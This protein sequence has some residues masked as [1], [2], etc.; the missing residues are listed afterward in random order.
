MEAPAAFPDALN[1]AVDIDDY[2]LIAGSEGEYGREA[3]RRI[4]A[5]D[6]LIDTID[7]YT[8]FD[9]LGRDKMEEDGVR[10]TGFGLLRRLSKPF[11]SEQEI[12]QTMV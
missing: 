2:E 12:G 1:I 10:Q 7:S 11:P 5:D 6:E 3:L 9:Q 8:D 4:G